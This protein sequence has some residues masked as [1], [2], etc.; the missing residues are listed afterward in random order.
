MRNINKRFT[1]NIVTLLLFPLSAAATSAW[2][3]N[4]GQK[5]QV[6]KGNMTT[7]T[8]Q[9]ALSASG[10]NSLLVTDPNLNFI[11]AGPGANGVRVTQ[12]AQADINK[13]SISTQGIY[14]NGASVDQGTLNMDGSSIH[15]AGTNAYGIS[16]TGNSTLN[17]SNT[18]ITLGNRMTE[19]IDIT[20][21]TLNGNGL[22]LTANNPT[23]LNMIEIS[24]QAQA[25]LKDSQIIL[26]GLSSSFGI[27][28]N[29]AT[30]NASNLIINAS[31]LGQ[32]IR[33][34][35]SSQ[36]APELTLNDSSI[37]TVGRTATAI[38]TLGLSVLNNVNIN[39]S[40][41]FGHGMSLEYA[42]SAQVNGGHIETSGSN[43]YG[44]W[45]TTRDSLLQVKDT[46]FSI[47]GE[48]GIAVAA[49]G[50]KAS[51]DN[52]QAMI[53]GESGRGIVTESQLDAKNINVLTTGNNNT[54]VQASGTKGDMTIGNSSITASGTGGA[55]MTAALG[56]K[57][58][59]DG[60]NIAMKGEKNIGLWLR[61]GTLKMANSHI[62]TANGPGLYADG[63]ALSEAALDNTQ[64]ESGGFGA[65][66]IVGS[67]LNLNLSNGTVATGGN[68]NVLEARTLK[69]AQGA[70]ARNSQVSLMSDNS[71]LNGNVISD[72]VD[73]QVNL[74][75]Q[76]GSTLTGMMKNVSSTLLDPTSIWN[77]T[78][79][80]DLNTFQLDG[81]VL[82]DGKDF[83]TLTVN[84]NLS[85]NGYL[86]MHTRLGG[87]DSPS[88]QLNV[89]G[90]AAGKFTVGITNQGGQGADTDIGIHVIHV[91]GETKNA[92]FTQSQ[93][94]VAGNYE[95]FLNPV[96]SHDWYLQSSYKPVVDP[97]APSPDKSYRP[98]TS[99]YL[100]GPY[101][102]AAYAYTA[103]G[104][105]HQRLGARQE[106]QAVWGRIY[107]RHDLYGAGRFGYDSN[108]AFMQLGGDL[109]R[110][111]LTPE[112]EGRSGVMVTI[113][114][115]HSHARDYARGQRSGLSV[116]T[117]K[118]NT[119]AYSLGGYFTADNEDGA[120]LDTVGQVTWYRNHYKSI[121]NT[122]QGSYSTLLSAEMGVPFTLSGELKLEPQL[123]LM[124]QYLHNGEIRAGGAKVD[125]SHDFMGQARGG[126]RL[127]YD[128][129]A[130]QPWVQIDTV[131]R[132]GK[133][134]NIAMNQE[135]LS[136]DIH[137]GWW[138][139][140]TG[141][142][143]Q[144]NP[145]LSLYADVSMQHSYGQGIEGYGG[146]V[147]VKYQF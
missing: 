56:G 94:I 96:N 135:S 2:D 146:N 116:N 73:N 109:W 33:V 85:G 30:L 145:A 51:L 142:R 20:G 58:N 117:G 44:I 13:A 5:L 37:S 9:H 66:Q 114:D 25:T 122:G 71:T 108:T 140:G 111:S 80:S 22:V 10:E 119:T 39:T 100:I 97:N 126:L 8:N 62:V 102:N 92:T 29:D 6:S 28:V 113:G 64:L 127:V 82:F 93:P 59:A 88:D 110:G 118:I 24:K 136:P 40:G 15:I 143:G 41:D 77:M 45:T 131:Q 23:V 115:I 21:G 128:A 17:L 38:S 57:I 107:G 133:I 95:Y 137:S 83:H 36:T 52:I 67:A 49:Q 32:G 16:A 61:K 50:G 14:G 3:V 105:Y 87:D 132:M 69:D 124:G 147:G 46:A 125:R 123:Q 120:Y 78:G 53:T 138:Q 130:V 60:I 18:R 31:N 98:E 55:G 27:R 74:N 99:G 89:K 63:N 84:N 34:E 141:I 35:S 47:S 91:A 81:K 12:G 68:G 43:A 104:T 106:G 72:S 129:E 121:N 90:D 1:F 54:G 75:L 101:L 144:V 76:N 19:G 139:L 134:P 86:G 42:G 65:F 4:D 48:S 11:T 103:A 79:D 7:G 112:I 70:D 26:N